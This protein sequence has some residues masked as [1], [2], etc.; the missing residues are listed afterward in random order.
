MRLALIQSG[1]VVNVVEAPAGWTPPA[2]L[3]AQVLPA[4][5]MVCPGC[6]FDG[7]LY[8]APPPPAPRSDVEELTD[9]VVALALVVLDAVNELRQWDAG[10]KA[11]FQNNTTVANI[12]TA[13]LALPNM[14]DRTRGQ[15]VS[16]VKDKIADGSIH[17]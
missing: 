17:G 4:D 15:L 5:S 16:A 11:A 9:K 7:T 13:V 1:T 2:G 6:L 14:P 3:T 8:T 12:R 10:L